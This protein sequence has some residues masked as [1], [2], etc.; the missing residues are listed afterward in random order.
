MW[1]R[2]RSPKLFI[3]LLAL[4]A[5]VI[6]V[7]TTIGLVLRNYIAEKVQRENGVE[8]LL[9]EEEQADA[10]ARQEA[11]FGLFKEVND[12]QARV[13]EVERIRTRARQRLESPDNTRQVDMLLIELAFDSTERG[14]K[15]LLDLRHREGI[16]GDKVRAHSLV[17]GFRASDLPSDSPV[18]KEIWALRSSPDVSDQEVF[19]GWVRAN[20]DSEHI[21]SFV[22]DLRRL[23]VPWAR[24]FAYEWILTHRGGTQRDEAFAQALEDGELEGGE[25]SWLSKIYIENGGQ[26][27][28]SAA[29]KHC[30]ATIERDDVLPISY[31][32]GPDF[33]A[34]ARADD[35]DEPGWTWKEAIQA[36]PRS[37][38]IIARVLA[39]SPQSLSYISPVAGLLNRGC[40]SSSDL[41]TAL[42][43]GLSESERAQF[44][45]NLS[46]IES[47]ALLS[48]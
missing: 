7:A 20:Q 43:E 23:D 4:I 15:E 22:D 17:V 33:L 42:P 27:L 12:P 45:E 3:S 47:E 39:S 34:L 14:I 29:I 11:W 26:D 16:L 36:E 32:F 8:K 46:L 5:S 31:V 41:R 37:V 2:N 18:L 48:Q 44:D 35:A 30:F 1:F 38:E 19:V 6:I 21:G 28:K 25:K 9:A 13:E 40:F 10:T 24:R